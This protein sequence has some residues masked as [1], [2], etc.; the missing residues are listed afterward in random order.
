MTSFKLNDKFTVVCESQNTRTGFRHVAVLLRNG[1]EVDRTKV[2]YQNRTWERFTFESVLCK[3][4]A[5]N[6]DGM[7]KDEFLTAVHVI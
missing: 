4:I 2:C 5:K 7:Q 6:F 1:D 3:I